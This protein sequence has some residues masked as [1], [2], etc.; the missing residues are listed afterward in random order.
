MPIRK[1]RAGRWHVE[2]CIQ[3]QRVHRRLAAGATAGDA[4]QLEAELVRALGQRRAPVVP[5]DP[6]IADVLADYTGRHAQQLRSPETATFHALRIGRWVEGR[7]CSEARQVAAAITADM[8]GHYA[9]GTINR[10][11]G[12]LK[13]ALRIAWDLGRTPV[14]HSQAVRRLPEH[15][16]R[17]TTLTM[18]QVQRLAGQASE[19]VRA[20]IWIALF[21]GMRRGEILKMQAAD[22]GRHELVIHAGNTKTQKTRT[23]PI[24]PPVRPWLAYVPLAITFE[25]LK[26]GFR[27]AREAAGLPEVQFRDLR[28]SCGSLMVQHGATLHQVQKVLGHS[29]PVVTERVYAH[30]ADRDLRQGMQGLVD[31]HRDLHRK[32]RRRA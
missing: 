6:L 2:V 5:G 15:N 7:R 18:Q 16:A 24:I 25:G 30:L 11:L 21:T 26:S 23:V 12:A 32:G 22:V 17:S 14:D 4:K 27:R 28:R 13:R 9:P 19:P 3:R 1:D 10:S 29:S 20:A 31:L 8:H